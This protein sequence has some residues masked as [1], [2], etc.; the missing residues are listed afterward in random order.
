MILR[1]LFI[2][3]GFLIWGL[4]VAAVRAGWHPAPRQRIHRS[5]QPVTFWTTMALGVMFG[6]VFVHIGFY[7]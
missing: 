1:F 7:V 3:A 4:V 6:A 5:Q 2:A